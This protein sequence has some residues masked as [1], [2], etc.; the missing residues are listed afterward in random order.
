MR[1]NQNNNGRN[2]RFRGRGNGHQN[3]GGGH[4]HNTHGGHSGGGQNRGRAN[5]RVTTFDSNG[6]DV[7]IRGNAYQINEKYLA[8]AKDAASAGDR[9]LAES[10]LQHAEHYQRMINEM[11]EEYNRYQAQFQQQQPSDAQ[12]P[13]APAMDAL[14]NAMVDD[15]AVQVQSTAPRAAVADE[16]PSDAGLEDIGFLRG[17]PRA[18]KQT[19]DQGEPRE[20]EQ[21]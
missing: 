8:L 7:R 1:H 18:Q 14:G 5:P 4:H 13:D 20:A 15:T 9:I 10:Y 12:M 17:K 2:N 6:P 16:Q 19:E 3:G 11:S 21:V